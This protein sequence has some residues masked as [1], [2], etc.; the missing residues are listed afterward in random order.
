M[1]KRLLNQQGQVPNVDRIGTEAALRRRTEDV[2]SARRRLIDE[3]VYDRK[4]QTGGQNL[5]V[6]VR[7]S[8][9]H[10]CVHRQVNRVVV[11]L[12]QP[13]ECCS[14]E[15]FR[16]LAHRHRVRMRLDVTM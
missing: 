12:R 1:K 15:A 2:H 7:P 4:F 8:R 3:Q 16:F 11:M 6:A 14:V 10:G 13:S 5:V 9:G